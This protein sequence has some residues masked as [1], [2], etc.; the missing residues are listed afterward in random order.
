VLLLAVMVL[1][2]WVLDDRLL[3]GAPHGHVAVKAN[4]AVGFVLAALG[5]ASVT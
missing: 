4:T 3:K 1:A 5:T 2:G